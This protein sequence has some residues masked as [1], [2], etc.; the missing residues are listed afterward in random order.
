MTNLL[1][2]F[3]EVYDELDANHQVD[4]ANDLVYVDMAKPFDKVHHK[5]LL[6]CKHVEYMEAYSHASP[7][8]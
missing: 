8:G 1:D 5:R 6:R 3:E 4:Q 2:F 7:G